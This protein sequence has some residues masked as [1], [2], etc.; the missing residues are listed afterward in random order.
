M[1]QRL[2]SVWFG[3]LLISV[4]VAGTVA[5]MV[6]WNLPHS[7]L[8]TEAMRLTGP[9]TRATGLDQNWSVFAPNPYRDSFRLTARI[10]YADGTTGRWEVPEGGAAIGAYWDFRWG[11]WA[12]WTLNAAHGDLC[13]GTARYVA[14]LEADE[15]RE[16]VRVDLVA[17]RRPNARPGDPPSRDGWT[18]T[19]FCE[20]RITPKGT[21]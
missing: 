16:P 13:G 19:V 20:N 17:H 3:R 21:S 2:E 15:G 4:F 14:N 9:Y 12:E 18:E 7:K 11:K 8:K 6:V 1:Q 10:T 5:A